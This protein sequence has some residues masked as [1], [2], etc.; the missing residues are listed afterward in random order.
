MKKIILICI[1]IYQK[2]L[3]PDHGFFKNIHSATKYK[4]R[5]YPSCSVYTT[6]AINKYGITKGVFEG[7]KRV[8]RCHPW[9]AGGYDPVTKQQ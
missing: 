6:D 8:G 3:S 5:F 2:T 4:C 9:S 1:G 7:M